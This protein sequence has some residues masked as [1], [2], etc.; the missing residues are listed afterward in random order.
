L[1]KAGHDW[2]NGVSLLAFSIGALLYYIIFYR[3]KL[4]PRWLSGWGLIGVIL[5]MASVALVTVG[6]IAPFST[7]QIILNLPILPQELVFAAW[8]IAKGFSPSVIASKSPQV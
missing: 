1:V 7:T 4:V 2:V 3:T 8:L 5:S 6:L